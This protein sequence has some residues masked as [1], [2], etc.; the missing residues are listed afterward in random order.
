M[1]IPQL[2][3]LA[4]G[5][6]QLLKQS[7][8][9]IGHNQSLDLIAA[10]PGLRNWP[11]VQAFPDRVAAA[12]LNEDAASRLAFRLNKKFNLGTSSAA[13][14]DALQPA[15]PARAD[16]APQ[17]WPTGP[18]PGVYVTDSESAI[19]A[20]LERYEEATDGAVVY[21]EAAG[22][23]WPASI[24]LGEGGL[25]SDGLERVPSGTLLVVG[26]VGLNQQMWNEESV[27][28]AMACRRAYESRH[29]VAVLV[30]TPSPW[31]MCEDVNLMVNS[32]RDDNLAAEILVGV[33][34]E[35]GDLQKRVPFA[36]GYPRPGPI[37]HGA[38]AEAIPAAAL[39]A[40]REA[41]AQARAGVVVVG[42][43][44]IEDH[45]AAALAAAM[46]ALTDAAGPAARIMPRHR[47]TPAK[48]WL[49]PEPI[50]AL[51][52]LPSIQ[53]AYQQG[54]RRMLFQPSHTDSDVLLDYSTECLLIGNTFGGEVTDYFT[55]LLHNGARV[56]EYELLT[57]VVA[58]LGVT[59]PKSEPGGHYATDLYV[60]PKGTIARLKSFEEVHA[61]L[62]AN[63]V[64]RWEDDM[65]QLLDSGRVS[66]ESLEKLFERHRHV[67][68]FLERRAE[69]QPVA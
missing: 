34:T 40:L 8:H 3:L 66:A 29:R 5:V 39:R 30:H 43:S 62:R 54:Y 21:A 42:S 12:Q 58:L 13:L 33:V 15:A 59:V 51:P 4:A 27:R 14:L 45:P 46:L 20:L 1:E 64:L 53:S 26:P 57:R 49:V 36:R 63:R 16:L 17:I 37:Q 38:S 69:A 44:L 68:E 35:E 41:L 2:K 18:A 60:R 47:G 6:R 52:F 56:D 32:A 10:I 9:E 19:T 48:D 61:F 25:W 31:A 24:D 22:S 23:G 65:S 50:K 11:E 7:Q 67:K 55:M 28:L